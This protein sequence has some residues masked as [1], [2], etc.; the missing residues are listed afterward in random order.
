MSIFYF[1]RTKKSRGT[2]WSHYNNGFVW[3]LD[4]ITGFADIFDGLIRV[5][6]LGFIGSG[7]AY[8]LVFCKLKHQKPVDME[9]K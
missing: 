9:D 2:G 4:W 6:S 7:L 1:V 3:I 8:K 5:L